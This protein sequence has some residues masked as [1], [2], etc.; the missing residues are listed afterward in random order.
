M[1][2]ELNN[3]SKVFPVEQGLMRKATGYVHAVTDVS[4]MIDKGQ[5]FALAGESGSGKTT[6]ALM[7]SRLITPTEGEIKFLR[8]PIAKYSRP[9]YG[10][11]VSM[12]FQNPYASLD[13]HLTVGYILEEARRSGGATQA[14][15][16]AKLEELLEI[17]GLSADTR[18]AYPFQL[19]GGQRQ[20]VAIARALAVQPMLIISDEP[21]SSLDV[22]LQAQIINLLAEIR[23]QLEIAFLFIA[24]DLSVVYQ[25][26]DS[27]AIM[28]NGRIVERGSVVDVLDNPQDEYT[29]KLVAS[30]LSPDP[31]KKII[32]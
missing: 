5:A 32:V 13:P 31:D 7:I 24:H 16:G 23:K 9:E 27:V 18:R 28:H 6:T 3:V 17:V 4:F 15:Q 30:I 26:A 25:F 29:K 19:S 22:S 21:V 12:I 14:A 20:R 10:R 2:L 1:L 11:C 8:K